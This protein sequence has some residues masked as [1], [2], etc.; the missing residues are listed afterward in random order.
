MAAGDTT[1][2]GGIFTNVQQVIKKNALMVDFQ[3]LQKWKEMETGN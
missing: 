2:L 3:G 1:S